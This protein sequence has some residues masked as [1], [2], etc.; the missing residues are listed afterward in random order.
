MTSSIA[1]VDLNRALQQMPKG[2]K[3][4]FFLHD[5]EDYSHGEIAGL[6]G[7]SEG[8]SKSQLHKARRRLRELLEKAPGLCSSRL[9][10]GLV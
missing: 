8:T 3:T 7:W 1:R 5:S 10:I 9:R 2:Y 4:A 6:T